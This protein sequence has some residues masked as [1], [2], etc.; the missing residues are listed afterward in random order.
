[1]PTPLL[2]YTRSIATAAFFATGSGRPSKAGS[3]G[4]VYYLDTRHPAVLSATSDSAGIDFT[5]ATGVRIGHLSIIEPKLPESENRIARQKGL[6]IDGF[7][8]RQLQRT[9][10]GAIYFRQSGEAFIDTERGITRERLLAPDAALQKLADEIADAPP[11]PRASLSGRLADTRMP[12]TDIFGTLGLSLPRNLF[13]AQD[14]LNTAAEEAERQEKG[15][16]PAI[17]AILDAHLDEARTAAA[18]ADRGAPSDPVMHRARTGQVHAFDDVDASL[19]ELE[20]IAALKPGVLRTHFASRRPHKLYNGARPGD[21]PAAV[22][23]PKAR[24]AYTVGMFLVGLEYMRTVGGATA[25]QY[26]QR[27]TNMIKV[28]MREI[29]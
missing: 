8:S 20:R 24:L 11:K 14:F 23:T 26:F 13:W 15:L 29:S 18:T 2:D 7:D 5:T 9:A 17:R 21:A 12:G 25:H 28:E 22:A 19:S 3:I 4:I 16:W 10:S 1:M 27:A 6:F